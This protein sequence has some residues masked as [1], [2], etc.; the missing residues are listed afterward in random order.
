MYTDVEFLLMPETFLP[1]YVSNTKD[2][3]NRRSL[4][5]QI[6]LS[7]Y[8]IN[9][10][11]DIIIKSVEE[12]ARF[13]TL[14]CLR[15][16]KAILRNNPFELELDS[17][18]VSKLFCLYKT[19]IVHKSEEVRACVNLL[20]RFQR[21]GDDEIGWLISNWENSE[22]SLNRLLRYPQ[23]HPLVVK[24]VNGIYQRGQL[25][26]R[27]AEVVALL[28]DES[29]PSFVTDTEDVIIWAIFH[30]RVEDAVKQKLLMEK[31]STK[32][33][34]LLWKI[35]LKLKYSTVIEFMRTKVRENYAQS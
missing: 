9:Y 31:F 25:R 17:E 12:G 18:T 29:V 34:D 13:R 16:I 19:F 23:K 35:A 7:E 10:L 32:N 15:V 28:I 8:A 27:Q 5:K 20:I 24:W 11:L 33:L 4:L 30:S 22:H 2:I 21:L 1:K 14:D 6:L 26:N 3:Y